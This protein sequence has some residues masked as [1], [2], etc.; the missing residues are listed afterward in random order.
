M[1]NDDGIKLE[2]LSIQLLRNGEPVAEIII[3]EAMPTADKLG[4]KFSAIAVAVGYSITFSAVRR[5][6][7]DEE[8]VYIK[9]GRKL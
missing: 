1:L 9:E 2:D 7:E 5:L 8:N 3:D 4:M 6:T